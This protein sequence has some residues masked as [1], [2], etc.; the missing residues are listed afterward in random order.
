MIS[1]NYL[2]IKS[3]TNLWI[4]SRTLPEES[5]GDKPETIVDAELVLHNIILYDTGVGVVPLIGGEPGHH[6]QGEGHQHIG[7]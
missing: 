5:T 2:R 1:L 3:F 4:K 7:S 6:K